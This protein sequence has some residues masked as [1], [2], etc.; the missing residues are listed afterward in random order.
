MTDLECL[1]VC[2]S[3]VIRMDSVFQTA[4]YEVSYSFRRR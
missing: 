4:E 1:P 3:D 2:N